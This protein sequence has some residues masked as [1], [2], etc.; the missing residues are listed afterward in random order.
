MM[1]RKW[2]WVLALI[3][4]MLVIPP[5]VLAAPPQPQ[6]PADIDDVHWDEVYHNTRLSFYRTPF[7]AVPTGQAI[8]LSLRTAHNDLDNATLVVYNIDPSTDGDSTQDGTYWEVVTTTSSSDSTYDYYTFVVPAQPTTRTLYYKFRLRDGSDCD[9]YVDNC[10]HNSYDHEDRCENGRGK[11]VEGK[12]GDQ[13]AD[14]DANYANNSFDIT[15]YDAGFT[16]PDWAQNA[17]IYQIFPDRF[18]NGDPGNDDAWPYSDVYSTPVHLHTTWNEAPDN[19]RDSS[20]SYY[21]HWSADFFGGDLQGIIDEL[22]Y[23]QGLGVTALYLNP[24]FAS[25]SNHGYDTSNYLQINPRFGTTAT[26]Q[27]LATEAH[28]R[29]IKLILD[30]V[31]NHTGSDS[32]YFD[33]YHRWDANGNPI[34]ATDGSG[35]CEAAG[36]SYADF[37]NL[38]ADSG[39]CYDGKNYDSWWGYDT[40]PLLNENAAVK[41]FIFDYNNDDATPSAV[42]QYWYSLGADGWRFD[43]ADELSH[44]FWKAFRAQ[45]KVID[46]LTG[47]LYSE[48]WYEATPWLY[49]DQM[50]ATM[51]Y[52]Y[53]KAVLGFLVDTDWTDNDNNGD[54]TIYALPPSTFDYVLG[55]IREDYPAPAWYG[56]MNLVGSHDANR[57][58][59]ILRQESTDLPAALAKMKMLAELQFT[60]PGAPTIYY[61]DE[62]GLGPSIGAARDCGAQDTRMATG[63]SKTIP[64]IATRTRGQTRAAACRAAAGSRCR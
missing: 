7:G 47:P 24:I 26:F 63:P 6:Q 4:G 2:M 18:R 59:Y 40:L 49:G 28:Q 55:S 50:D 19:P 46:T 54:S 14:S 29:G 1:E 31:F 51:N 39:P 20:S 42:I 60:Y 38:Y 34:T 9:W 52:R 57:A 21:N 37:Y 12:S 25:P 36:S 11:M 35:A 16:V 8:T 45:V 53:R 64:T 13:C 58:L 48:V 62:V 27:T 32:T 3:L 44:D 41:D 10:A 56:M 61:G 43:V 22:D 15:V 33:R 5:V 30:G 17:V 23:L